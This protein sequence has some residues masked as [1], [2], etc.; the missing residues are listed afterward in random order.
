MADVCLQRDTRPISPP[1]FQPGPQLGIKIESVHGGTLAMSC[2]ERKQHIARPSQHDGAMTSAAQNL[3]VSLRFWMDQKQLTQQAL[4]AK[5]GV[6]QTTISL[7]LRPE[8]RDQTA[9]GTKGS[10]TL[11]NIEALAAAL[12]VEVWQLLAPATS[13]EL[14]LFDAVRAVLHEQRAGYSTPPSKHGKRRA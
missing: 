10:P 1:A 9:R 6:G 4:S 3:A 8:A 5:S 2:Y 12:G 7:Y 13:Q 14:G 11:A